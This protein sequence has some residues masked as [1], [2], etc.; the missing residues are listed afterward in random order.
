M[1][2]AIGGSS[3]LAIFQKHLGSLTP[4]NEPENPVLERSNS[5]KGDSAEFDTK[6]LEIEAFSQGIKGANE[7]IGALQSAD[8]ALKKMG[9]EGENLAW[10]HQSLQDP[11]MDSSTQEA[12]KEQL[13]ESQEKISSLAQNSSFMGKKLFDRELVNEVGGERFSLSLQ[14]PS[15]LGEESMSYIEGKRVEISQT[16]SKVSEA[17]SKGNSTPNPNNYN[18]EEFD[19]SAFM[20]LF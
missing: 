10:I 1:I 9:K 4:S 2:N 17:I 6:R 7:F 5:L 15:S 19:A 14:D 20:K 18:F 13:Q 11:L 8:V 16:L 3:N 12:L